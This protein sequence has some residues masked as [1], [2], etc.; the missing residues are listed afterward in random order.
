[1]VRDYRLVYGR[2]GGQYEEEFDTLE[3]LLDFVNDQEEM[4]NI[5]AEAIYRAEQ[6]LY[7]RKPPLPRSSQD[8]EAPRG[9][10]RYP[11]E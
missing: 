5:W 10:E 9:F 2:Y 7:R 6:P 3:D 4:G 1:M 8:P 11:S